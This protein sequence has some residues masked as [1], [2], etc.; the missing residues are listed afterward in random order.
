MLVVSRITVFAYIFSFFIL[1]CT[2]TLEVGGGGQYDS[3]FFC[4]RKWASE[5]F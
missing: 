1:N 5:R 3:P 4:R 2:P